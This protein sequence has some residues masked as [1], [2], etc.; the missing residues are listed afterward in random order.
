MTKL[1]FGHK[2]LYHIVIY[3]HLT[4]KCDLGLGG[5]DLGVKRDTS[6]NYGGHLC[7]AKWNSLDKWR[8]YAPD[9]KHYIILSYMDSWPISVT[10]NLGVGTWVLS[11]TNRQMMGNICAKLD[12][13]CLINEDVMFRTQNII[14]YSH[15]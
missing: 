15:I 12:E 10:L 13:I 11:A 14:S 8:S 2:K 4:Y 1:C 9:T 7:Q 5:Y 3:R 6:F